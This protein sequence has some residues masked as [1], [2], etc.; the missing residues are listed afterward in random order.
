MTT[1]ATPTMRAMRQ[2]RF[3]GPEVLELTEVPRP[4]PGI[5]EVLIRVKAAGLNPTDCKHR[6][7]ERFLGQPPYSFGWDVA[8]VIEEV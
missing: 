1:D 2:E 8:W 3:G 6:S 7:A 5:S 4:K